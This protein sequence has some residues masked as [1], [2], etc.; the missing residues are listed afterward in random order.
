MAAF[1]LLLTGVDNGAIANVLAVSDVG[2]RALEG[3]G[4]PPPPPLLVHYDLP[5][6]KVTFL[7]LPHAAPCAKACPRFSETRRCAARVA[8]AA[9]RAL[10]PAHTQ[11]TCQGAFSRRKA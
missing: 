5:A 8:A 4:A 2:L 9:V 10:R 11:G 6:R 7:P 3:R 1:L